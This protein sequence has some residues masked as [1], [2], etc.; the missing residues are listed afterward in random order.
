[1]PNYWL[2]D[3]FNRSLEC[4]VLDGPTYRV[5]VAGRGDDELRPSLFPG[6]VIRLGELWGA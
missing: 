2:I 6:L 5:D 4:L 1:M 3:A